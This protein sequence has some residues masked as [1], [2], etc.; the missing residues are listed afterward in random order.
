MDMRGPAIEAR[1]L[2]LYTTLMLWHCY[3]RQAPRSITTIRTVIFKDRSGSITALLRAA[4]MAGDRARRLQDFIL[5]DI[6][7]PFVQLNLASR[8]RSWRP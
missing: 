2:M 1:R 6:L 4:R 5:T 8:G 7:T 3:K